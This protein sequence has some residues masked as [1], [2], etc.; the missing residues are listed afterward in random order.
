MK[1]LSFFSYKG[2]SGRSTLLY[3]ILPIL[4]DLNILNAS[5][6]H[7]IVVVDMDVD[8]AGI[9]FLTNA[10]NEVTDI[11][12]V[13]GLLHNGIPKGNSA[14]ELGERLFGEY[15]CS[16]GNACGLYDNDA[17]RLLPAKEGKAIGAGKSNNYD[18]D[19]G[20]SSVLEKLAEVCEKIGCPAL[21]LDS[22]V[23][24]QLF[25][26]WSL[27]LSEIIVTCMRPT[28][29]FREGTL[30]FFERFDRLYAAKR[31]IV[32]PNTVPLEPATIEGD[33]YPGTSSCAIGLGFERLNSK[34]NN[35]Y[36]MDMLINGFGIPRVER[37]MW[38]EGLLHS[39]RDNEK[40][41]DEK[42]AYEKM[43][44]LANIIKNDINVDENSDD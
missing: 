19:S 26:Q 38:K 30:R 8:S 34:N 3:N 24:D 37:F 14:A 11:R 12:S 20:T 27:R 10:Q 36:I 1:T 39:I 7:P 5:S 31:I 18:N 44:H 42:L 21:I 23:G 22:A 4:A 2:G 29:Q 16:I 17:I 15:F 43:R 9:T 25:A 35:K 6:Q 41:H 13:Q 33:N 32:V 28:M 40:K